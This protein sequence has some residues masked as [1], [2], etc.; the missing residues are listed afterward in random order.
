MCKDNILSL[1]SLCEER[2]LFGLYYA[3]SAMHPEYLE[4][5]FIFVEAPIYS[6][7]LII[8]DMPMEGG[9]PFTVAHVVKRPMFVEL[10][11]TLRS[12][13]ENGSPTPYA[14]R[15]FNQAMMAAMDCL[16]PNGHPDNPYIRQVEFVI[17]F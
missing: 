12:D 2:G 9:F 1:A 7:E 6:M 15:V 8:E 14:M 3:L 11:E 17:G 16:N 5:G 13:I 4:E 10:L